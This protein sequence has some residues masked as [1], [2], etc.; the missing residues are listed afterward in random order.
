MARA[1]LQSARETITRPQSELYAL[2][3]N[4]DGGGGFN[5]G[6]LQQEKQDMAVD[7]D[8]QL[9]E[10]KKQLVMVTNERDCLK[11]NQERVKATLEGKIRRL[12]QQLPA[13]VS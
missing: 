8:W 2:K 11:Q 4:G 5:V 13:R 12:E 7:Y 9:L 3:T 10:L 1:Q 6:Q